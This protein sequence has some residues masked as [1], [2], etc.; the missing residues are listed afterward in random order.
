MSFRFTKIRDSLQG[1]LEERLPFMSLLFPTSFKE[2]YPLQ[3]AQ[4]R[5]NEERLTTP[6]D[7]HATLKDIVALDGKPSTILSP[8]DGTHPKGISLFK[9]IPAARTCQV[10]ENLYQYQYP[11]NK[12]RQ[13]H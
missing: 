13:R 10:G 3:F 5:A 1:K 6:L 2:K 9:S 8:K 4:L 12:H 11:N 7:L